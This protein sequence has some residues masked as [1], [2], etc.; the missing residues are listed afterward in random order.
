LRAA[1]DHSWQ[2][3]SE[4]EKEV[5][6]RLSVFRGGF[7]REAAQEVAGASL[8]EITS[9]L[10]KSL[11]KRVGEDR[12]DLHELIRQYGASRLTSNTL[13]HTETCDRHS[14]Y[15]AALLEQWERQ[16]RS[17]KQL[18]ILAEMDIEIDNV[19]LAWSWMAARKLTSYIQKSLGSLWHFHEI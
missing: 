9:L 17:P 6:P 5:F 10:D 18:D 8:E 4:R 2:L 1:L 3:L 14:R 7:R 13:D 19:R 15:Y 12:Y 16:V 11:L